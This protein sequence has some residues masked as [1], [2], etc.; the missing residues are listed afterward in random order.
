MV[1]V[2]EHCRD[3]LNE[4]LCTAEAMIVLIVMSKK[5]FASY[6]CAVEKHLPLL[7]TI[8]LF[9]TGDYATLIRYLR[10]LF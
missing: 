4:P 3:L 2:G 6:L 9:A 10:F 7:I 1:K 8:L 5:E